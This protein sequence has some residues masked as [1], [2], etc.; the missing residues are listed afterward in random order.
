[1]AMLLTGL[2]AVSASE[3]E[4]KAVEPFDRGIGRS[5]V[6]FIPKGTVGMGVSFS[7]RTM[8]LG[9]SENDAGY[10]LLSLVTGIKGNMYTFGLA[11]QVSYFVADNLSLGA[12]F[13]Y[14]RSVLDIGNIGL[15]L[16]D[17][18]SMQIADYHYL[19]QS[20]S[21]ALTLRYYMPIADS[22]RFAMFAEAR[23]SGGY[24]QSLMYK[25]DNGDKFG[26]YQDIYKGSLDFVP[27]LAVFATDN[28]ALEVSVGILG[29]NYS[30]TKQTTN[31][32]ETSV[33]QNSGANFR[34]NLL[35]I[36][37]GLSFYILTGEHRPNKK[38]R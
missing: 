28:V 5:A 10:S 37:M 3:K 12:R 26:T 13:D 38:G 34:L 4:K 31:Q 17:M 36:N 24:G 21:G 27:G 9:E 14:D 29:I 1:M 33:M 25:M 23:L 19:S 8:G 15:S 2:S 6:T 18:L 7:Y 35:S 32:V 16:G 22:K 30:M 11:P 20:F